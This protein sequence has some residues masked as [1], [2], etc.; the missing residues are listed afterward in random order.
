MNPITYR[1]TID[2]ARNGVQHVLSG[3]KVGDTNR[4]LEI[5]LTNNG[6]PYSIGKDVSAKIGTILPNGTKHDGL[7]Q[8]EGNVIIYDVEEVVLSAEGELTLELKLSD[9]TND[10]FSSAE[11]MLLVYPQEI[12][13]DVE[14]PIGDTFDS[15]NQALAYVRVASD[16]A[17][18]E[19]QNAEEKA[20][21]ASDKA[22]E[23]RI[24]AQDANIASASATDSAKY[25]KNKAIKT[26]SVNASGNLIITRND[27]TSIDAGHVKGDK[28][29]KGDPFTYEDFTY[30]QL[31]NLKGEK[32][33]KGDSSD[34]ISLLANA[35]KGKASGNIV[36][37][38]DQSPLEHGLVV[39][40]WSSFFGY[41]K[42]FKKNYITYPHLYNEKESVVAS[43]ITYTD[44]GDN[45]ITANGTASN[46][47]MFKFFDMEF[48]GKNM[49]PIGDYVFFGCGEEGKSYNSERP[50]FVTLTLFDE[51]GEKITE[52]E[53]NRTNRLVFFSVS[54]PVGR[55]RCYV[56]VQ[57]GVEVI[58]QKFHSLLFNVADGEL[59]KRTGQR[60]EGIRISY[61]ETY[62]W[63]TDTA[64]NLL[65]RPTTP[66]SSGFDV[67]YNRDLNKAFEELQKAIFNK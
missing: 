63:A 62:L 59:Y 60:V 64:G 36:L 7:C 31:A 53:S 44:N 56:K 26:A 20:K 10:K 41:V 65:V 4:R 32:G 1:I 61:P 37:I 50:F 46:T 8:I 66:K 2:L 19:A 17:N 49:P 3:F 15:V 47:A 35:L 18:L 52:V 33:D 13:D 43:G 16:R 57:N 12:P 54:K 11:I 39:N 40:L 30:E 14:P 22:E 34:D 42:K 45:T 58:D 23:A 51:N 28:G 38:Q 6:I 48:Y 29:D 25:A 55:I 21:I 5:R 9:V 24:A 67:E 27:N